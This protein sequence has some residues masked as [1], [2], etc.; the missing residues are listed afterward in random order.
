MYVC[1]AWFAE[2]GRQFK[3]SSS[4][5]LRHFHQLT[6][7]QRIRLAPNNRVLLEAVFSQKN[8][9]QLEIHPTHL[10]MTGWNIPTVKE[11]LAAQLQHVERPRNSSLFLQ[12]G[13]NYHKP[14][15]ALRPPNTLQQILPPLYP[16]GMFLPTHTTPRMALTHNIWTRSTLGSQDHHSQSNSF[17]IFILSELDRYRKCLSKSHQPLKIRFNNSC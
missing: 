2:L 1:A 3:S 13:A 11:P 14:L 9:R 7:T 15:I 6:E 10:T 4:G 8:L 5:L 12:V 16:T 17:F